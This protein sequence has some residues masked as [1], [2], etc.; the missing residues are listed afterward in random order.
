LHHGF[1]HISEAIEAYRE[2]LSQVGES[3]TPEQLDIVLHRQR[4]VA[5]VLMAEAYQKA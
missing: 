1:P 3:E 2:T 4:T 5:I